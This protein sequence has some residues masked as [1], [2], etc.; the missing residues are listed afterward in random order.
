MDTLN[1]AKKE[2]DDLS[3]QMSSN[4]SAILNGRLNMLQQKLDAAQSAYNNSLAEL[5][6]KQQI[7]NNL[8]IDVNSFT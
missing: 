8:R 1:K 5:N 3:A 2:F 6:R 7:E 4:N